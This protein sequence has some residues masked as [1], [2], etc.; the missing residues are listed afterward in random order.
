MGLFIDSKAQSC[1]LFSSWSFSDKSLCP[2]LNGEEL[3]PQAP[4]RV[5][6]LLV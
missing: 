2:S 6:L 1:P 4:E 3:A 5:R